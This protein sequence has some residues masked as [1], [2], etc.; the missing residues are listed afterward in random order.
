MTPNGDYTADQMDVRQADFLAGERTYARAVVRI[1]DGI[2]YGE[3]IQMGSAPLK[4]PVMHELLL[5]N[6]DE[7]TVEREQYM[8]IALY[9]RLQD[10]GVQAG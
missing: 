2:A 10:L 5:I 8:G 3:H 9:H 4:I 6:E 1:R 7:G